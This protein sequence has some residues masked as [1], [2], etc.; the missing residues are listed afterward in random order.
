MTR[1][2]TSW[3]SVALLVLAS[4][5]VV[6]G[7][8]LPWFSA[9]VGRPAEAPLTGRV[10]TVIAV[11]VTTLLLALGSRWVW[12]AAGLTVIAGLSTL[13]TSGPSYVCWDGADDQGRPIGGC[14]SDSWTLAAPLFAGGLV[15][16]TAVSVTL[17]VRS[18]GAAAGT[19][20]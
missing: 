2:P 17:V 16:L 4:A 11:L 14:A 18:R 12:L 7:S 1:R 6:T 3:P 20:S 13:L 19:S 10:L 5:L 9:E 15:V 8:V